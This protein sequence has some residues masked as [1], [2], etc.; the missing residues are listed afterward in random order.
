MYREK[1]TRV[2]GISLLFSVC[3]GHQFFVVL[4]STPNI[5][6]GLGQRLHQVLLLPHCT[7]GR[8][9]E[10][11]AEEGSLQ[12]RCFLSGV[13]LPENTA[14]GTTLAAFVCAARAL[15]ARQT[16][17]RSLQE[18][19]KDANRKGD[20]TLTGLI[21]GELCQKNL[22]SYQR[23]LIG[24][25]GKGNMADLSGYQQSIWYDATREIIYSVKDGGVRRNS[26]RRSD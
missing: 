8:A 25:P 7:R 11:R 19:I 5:T 10:R 18:R 14:N 24:F 20:F 22:I 23:K 21:K 15:C 16:S 17:L 3:N 1:E 2:F 12:Q 26:V 6:T 9:V 4:N 13:L